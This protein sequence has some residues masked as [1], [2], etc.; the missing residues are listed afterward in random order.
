[1][2]TIVCNEHRFENIEAVLFDKDGT[3]ANVE[4]YLIRLGMVRSQEIICRA[5][6]D[7]SSLLSAFG[8]THRSIDPAGLMAVGSRYENEIAAAAYVAASGVGWVA[9]TTLVKQAFNAGAT[10]LAEK[11]G[12]TPILP[13]ANRLIRALS[14]QN[15]KV[16]IVSSDIHLEVSKF[17]QQYNLDVDWYCGVGGADLTK[18]QAGFLFF[19][20]QQLV[21][22]P[23]T[24]LV[25]GDSA[26]DRKLSE[27]GAAGFIGVTGGWRSVR[28]HQSITAEL[29]PVVVT[30]LDQVQTLSE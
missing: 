25:I 27:Q 15:V 21:S 8:Q 6:I 22:T 4:D 2:A 7:Q 30:Q 3:L 24:T 26:S 10:Q 11:S 13:G 1:M 23:E 12:Q 18:T 14:A 19:A 5:P 28:S 16:G 17:I 29:G 9:A 20:C